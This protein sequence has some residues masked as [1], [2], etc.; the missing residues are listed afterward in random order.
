MIDDHAA[1]V[2]YHAD[3]GGGRCVWVTAKG[4]CGFCGGDKDAETELTGAQRQ[5]VLDA[6]KRY[7][8]SGFSAGDTLAL[9]AEVD[10]IAAQEV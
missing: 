1:T 8:A 9:H 3:A 6:M 5:R 4:Y 7:S 10:A 2:A